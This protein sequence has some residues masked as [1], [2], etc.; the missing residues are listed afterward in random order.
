MFYDEQ[1][2]CALLVLCAKACTYCDLVVHGFNLDPGND[3]HLLT[4]LDY[5]K[6]QKTSF[7]SEYPRLERQSEIAYSFPRSS[8]YYTQQRSAI[9]PCSPQAQ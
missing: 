3:G 2:R 1:S 6:V 5:F 7:H 8:F 9:S 4:C